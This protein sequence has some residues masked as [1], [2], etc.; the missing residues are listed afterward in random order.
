MSNHIKIALT[1]DELLF[2]KGIL[3]MLEREE[4]IEVILEASNGEQLLNFL[5]ENPKNLPDIILMDLKMPLLNGV[6]ATKIIQKKYPEIKIIALTSY[7]S[8]PFILNMIQ[9]GASSYLVKNDSPKDMINTINEVHKNGF[10]YNESIMKILQEE[11]LENN[12][13]VKSKFDEDY[14]TSREKDVLILICKQYSTLEIAEKLFISPRT[15]DG[16]RN[17]LLLKTESKKITGLVVFAIQNGI[18]TIDQINSR[19]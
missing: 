3:F 16:H 12:K 9:E 1:D 6:E 7:D 5:D 10:H 18:I 8:K 19:L 4:N 13:K 14:L 11:I 2:R 17:N 15:V